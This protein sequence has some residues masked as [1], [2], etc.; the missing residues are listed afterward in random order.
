MVNA[1]SRHICKDDV[2]GGSA[3]RQCVSVDS[4]V[5]KII[6]RGVGATGIVKRRTRVG[7]RARAGDGVVAGCGGGVRVGPSIPGEGV[8]VRSG[9]SLG[10][11]NH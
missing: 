4:S 5:I 3:V 2:V 6:N 8:G 11:N 9:C 10:S 7:G 1:V